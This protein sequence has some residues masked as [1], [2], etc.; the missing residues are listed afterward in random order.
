MDKKKTY[1]AN[2][3]NKRPFWFLLG[4][5]FVLST[6]F[7]ALEYN[8]GG[9][10][11]YFAD[12][13]EMLDNLDFLAHLEHTEVTIAVQPVNK[14]TATTPAFVSETSNTITIKDLQPNSTEGE[15]EGAN[16][17]EEMSSIPTKYEEDSP[18]ETIT[19]T[20]K[21]L[22][23]RVVQEIPEYPGGMSALVKWLTDNLRYPAKAR[24]K[25]IEGRVMVSFIINKDGTI[26][27]AKIETSVDPYLDKEAMRLIR[28]MPKW[29]PGIED[30]KPC[31]T[32]FAIPINF[33]L[34]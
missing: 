8:S 12:S 30:G 5:V 16:N 31:R 1:Q 34:N 24:D 14:P 23:F 21:P 15:T 11:D 29:K 28:H 4:M 22:N 9:G 20:D 19:P 3:E 17:Q 33:K 18:K 32:L 7:A 27:D 25:K 26:S 2:L 10:D 6:F 13:D